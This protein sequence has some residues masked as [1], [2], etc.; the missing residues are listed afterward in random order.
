[1]HEVE[2]PSRRTH[3]IHGRAEWGIILS[4]LLCAA[5]FTATI[6]LPRVDNHMVGSDGVRYYAIT[7]SLVLDRDFDFTNDYSL[8]G[9]KA[10]PTVTGLPA[11]AQGIG[12]ALLWIPFFLVAHVL[13]LLLNLVGLRVP[14]NGVS[15]VYEASVCL[16]TIVYATLGFLMTYRI[17][18]RILG[19]A[20]PQTLWSILA[21]WWATP[22]IYYI[23]A[24]PS[25]SH[26]VTVFT[27]AAFL[28]LWFPPSPTRTATRWSM[29]GLA[30]GLAALVRWQD[31]LVILVPLAEL[32][33]WCLRG[34]VSPAR[35]LAYLG[36]F[37]SV[38][39]VVFLPQ[40]FMWKTVYGSFLTIPQGGGFFS[41]ASPHVL[42]ALFSMRHGLITWHPIF[43]LGLLGLIPLWKVDRRVALLILFVF[44]G[45]LYVNSAA[46]HWWADDAF[47]GRRFVSLIPL[48]TVPTA[49]LLA[50]MKKQV[51]AAVLAALVLWNGLGLAQYRL[52]FVSMSQALTIREMTLGRLEVPV[53]LVQ[54]LLR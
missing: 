17:T 15:Y 40:L 10:L 7:R 22:A 24:E 38:M 48:L 33:W 34:R 19:S 2:A 18:V 54:R 6:P 21:M 32:G 20:T 9:E 29:L 35:A 43:L 25:M 37:L 26:G 36:L 31:G 49:L 50:R 53:E 51:A 14:L 5:I 13:S 47:G 3:G 46:S 42:A 27:M 8:L 44:A 23:I 12:T 45:E 39:V 30:A 1:M 41:W 52:G 11:N 4:G 28:A 16:G